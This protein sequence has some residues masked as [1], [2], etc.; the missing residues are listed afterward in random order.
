MD[1]LG[2]RKEGEGVDGGVGLRT[3]SRLIGGHLPSYLMIAIGS[4][5]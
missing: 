2:E 5:L 1:G 4:W 3:G